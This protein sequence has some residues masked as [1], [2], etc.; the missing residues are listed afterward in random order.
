MST[1]AFIK[2][3]LQ[4]VAVYW[5]NPVNRGNGRFD[6]DDPI[7]IRCRWEDKT[8]EFAADDD[9]GTKYVSRSIVYTSQVL[10]VDGK[11]FLGNLAELSDHLDSSGGTYIDP[12]NVEEAYL[13]KRTEKIPI[14]GSST[15]FL[16]K[17]FL[18]PLVSA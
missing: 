10:S 8:Q 11:L 15:K 7:E 13:I 17:V 6:Y 2:R 16:Y 4:Q 9:I 1:P 5:G 3:N 18:T 14:L 12:I